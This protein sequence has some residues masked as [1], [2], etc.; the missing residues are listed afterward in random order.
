MAG[1][2]FRLTTSP[3]VFS[4]FTWVAF[5]LKLQAQI[6]AAA[7]DLLVLVT[8]SNIVCCSLH[9]ASQTFKFKQRF[10]GSVSPIEVA[11]RSFKPYS[12]ASKT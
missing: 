10:S 2:G 3:R 8:P 9:V 4:N 1:P 6:A 7:L 12:N 11:R 5:E